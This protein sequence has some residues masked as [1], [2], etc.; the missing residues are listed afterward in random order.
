MIIFVLSSV[1][2]IKAMA[3]YKQARH[4]ARTRKPSKKKTILL[5]LFIIALFV[6]TFEQKWNRPSGEYDDTQIEGGNERETLPDSSSPGLEFPALSGNE[7]LINYNGFTVSYNSKAKIPYWVAYTLEKYET[8]GKSTR[9]GIRFRADNSLP[10]PQAEDNDYRNSGWTRGHMAPAADFKWSDEAIGDTFYLT[11]CCP[12]SVALNEGM[13]NTLENKTRK[14][15]AKYERVHIITG[16]VI[17]KKIHGTIGYGEVVVPDAFFKALLIHDGREYHSI[18]FIMKNSKTEEEN[19]DDNMQRCAM[20][21][22]DLEKRI[23]YDLFAA[24][25]DTIEEDVE[26]RCKFSMWGL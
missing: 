18:A 20:S 11:N 21:V 3:K 13:W 10:Y 22:N 26:E 23:G 2:T 9:E 8:H 25:D 19:T 14:Y 24:L 4:G 12:Q 1:R 15:A 16:P 5:I 7:K 17:G 6:Y